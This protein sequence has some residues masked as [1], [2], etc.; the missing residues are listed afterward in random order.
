MKAE[1]GDYGEP[2]VAFGCRM[3]LV[4]AGVGGDVDFDKAD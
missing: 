4:I 2:N 3:G 1:L